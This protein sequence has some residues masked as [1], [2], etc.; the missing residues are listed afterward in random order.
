MAIISVFENLF[1]FRIFVEKIFV[2]Y[3]S[4]WNHKTQRQHSSTRFE[5]FSK[6]FFVLQSFITQLNKDTTTDFFIIKKLL[7]SLSFKFFFFSVC[8]FLWCQCFMLHFFPL[9][10]LIIIITVCANWFFSSII[11]VDSTNSKNIFTWNPFTLWLVCAYSTHAI[12]L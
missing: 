11:D 4:F 10:Y 7:F 1:F 5:N 9:C 8:L 3:I 12:T 2:V 6:L